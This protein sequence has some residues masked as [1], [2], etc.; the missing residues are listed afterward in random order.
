MKHTMNPLDKLKESNRLKAE[1]QAK[2]KAHSELMNGLS[3]LESSQTQA[4]S[5]LIRFIDGKT[6]KT[7]VVN[8]LE[9]IG[10]PDAFKVMSAVND[11]HSTLKKLKNTDLS[12]V[13]DLLSKL[14][15]EV[16]QIPKE[17]P[18]IP[19]VDSVE[20]NNLPDFEDYNAKLIE[21]VRSID[22]K[23]VVNLPA[24]E[25][26]VD[27]PVI[28]LENDFTTLEKALKDVV[29]A[30]Q[31]QVFPEPKDIDLTKVEKKLDKANEHL[32]K[33]SNKSFGGGGSG[34]HTTPYQNDEGNPTYITLVDGKIPV[35]L[36]SG[37]DPSSFYV[38]DI[39]EDTT[40]YYGNTNVSGAW[41]V[42]KVTD[43]LVSYATVTNNVAVTS[44]TDA[45]TDRAT[46]TYGR[47]D[48]A[49]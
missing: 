5:A 13:T 30:I 18:E 49:F 25:V 47:I 39:E 41:M 40:S 22:V 27:A 37:T 11:M 14:V 29:S 3:R 12:P 36:T 15:T 21:A 32:E 23:P 48:E 16:S 2:A 42:K 7:E 35:S 17:N 34:G 20:I 28:N 8:Q 1:A 26:K 31:N 43:T 10:T 33:I 9:K 6:T 44:Y 45:W 4:F 46:L 38:Y 19:E 24:P